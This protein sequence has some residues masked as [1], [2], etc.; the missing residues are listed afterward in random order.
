MII[1]HHLEKEVIRGEAENP[2]FILTNKKQ[3][4]LFLSA[5]YN[6]SRFQGAYFKNKSDMFKTI[7]N[8]SLV[9]TTPKKIINKF[10]NIK[11][12]SGSVVEKFFM[13][14]SNSIL[15]N[16]DNF[17]GD[18]EVTLDCRKMY[19]FDDKGRIYNIKKEKDMLIIEYIKYANESLKKKKYTIY[20]VIKGVK[21]Y[22]VIDSWERKHYEYDEKRGSIPFELYVYKALKIKV[23]KSANLVFSFSDN[24]SD[25]VKKATHLYKN[26][27]Y[28]RKSQKTYVNNICHRDFN[29]KG[30]YPRMAYSCASKSLN[31]L[32]QEIG[33][34]EGIYAGLPW[35]YQFWS[36]DEFI[37][38][39]ALLLN[40]NYSG[41][42]NI[43]S[44]N[45]KN[46]QKD[47]RLANINNKKTKIGSADSVGW[48]FKRI[49]DSIRIMKK[50]KV[51]KDY[52]SKKEISNIKTK[53]KNSIKDIGKNYMKNMLIHN[54]PKETWMDSD[55]DGDTREGYRIEIQALYLN[56]IKFMKE[57]CED[58]TSDYTKY[59]IMEKEMTKRVKESFYDHHLLDGIK[60]YKVR[61]NIFLAY[62]IYPEL[63]KKREWQKSFKY[64]L[65]RLWLHWG[66][67]STIGKDSSLFSENS[68]GENSKSYHRGDS[69]FFMNN[70]AAV[71]MH[72]LNKRKY[73]RY[74][75]KILVASTNE[76][77][78]SGVVGCSAEISSASSF[79]SEGCF[80]QA[81]SSATYIEL[82]NELFS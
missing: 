75:T 72:K 50:R 49:Q 56:M 47:G 79:K 63:L 2:L 67:L 77:L 42:K 65:K 70:L 26:Y 45:L 64:A 14:H 24:K 51:L 25:A 55:F 38:L 39:K 15:Y 12:V 71:C 3:G 32:V 48:M 7:E 62:Y 61:P 16:V 8:I 34:E 76:I 60:D 13:N 20:T 73:K 78:F 57:L 17:T 46:I 11:R 53:L 44:R 23:D 74:I 21:D 81:W 10:Y 43:I 36:R 68:T 1:K 29:I 9:G 18:V 27:P 19:D 31:D 52:F 6:I 4:F 37:S 82:I 58:K 28:L 54:N 33:K 80:S 30:E 35:F 41:V 69:W 66:G 59:S 40:K 22:E 5:L